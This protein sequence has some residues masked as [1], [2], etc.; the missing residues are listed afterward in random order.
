MPVTVT[1]EPVNA[2]RATYRSS[3]PF[4]VAETR[5]RSTIQREQEPVPVTELATSK[6][7]IF[8]NKEA[9]A[10]F[11][12]SRI[13]PH[14]F[15]HFHEINH[16][17]WLQAYYPEISGAVGHDGRVKNLRSIRF[18]LG[19]PLIAQTML[20]HD[21]DTGLSVPVELLLAEEVDGSAKV[22]HFLPSGL[23]A[24]YQG[25]SEELIQAAK[26]LEGKVEV[27]INWVLRDIE[28]DESR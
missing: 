21:L 25:A 12:E 8:P 23:I 26:V 10:Q 17:T 22:V 19:N 6:A 2:P 9:F 7:P 14:G 13:G 15:M 3:V 27:L 24:G 11:I 18:L 1:T 28:A 4:S 16:G 20:R 5:L